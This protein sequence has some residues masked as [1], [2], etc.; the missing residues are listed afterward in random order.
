MEDITTFLEENWNAFI[1]HLKSRGY[2]DDDA[3]REAENQIN[4]LM[5]LL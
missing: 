4:K 2:P 5:E 3:E 1:E